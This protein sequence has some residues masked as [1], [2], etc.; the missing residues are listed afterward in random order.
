MLKAQSP[1]GLSWLCAKITIFSPTD[2]KR[3]AKTI[4]FLISPIYNPLSS[5]NRLWFDEFVIFCDLTIPCDLTI[6]Q[7]DDFTISASRQ[8]NL[9]DN[10][11]VALSGSYSSN[12]FSSV[13]CSI[14]SVPVVF[15]LFTV[16]CSPFSILFSLFIV[17]FHLFSVL[18]Y[19]FSFFAARKHGQTK[20]KCAFPNSK[21]E[22]VKFNCVEVLF[23]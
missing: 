8:A 5:D 14:F 15:H 17:V 6:S 18:F 13:L 21:A 1:V 23:S 20:N 10:F 11:A 16:L 19:L 4:D 22:S 9:S 7:F 3:K 12:F 2:K